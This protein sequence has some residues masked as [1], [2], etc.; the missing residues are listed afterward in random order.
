MALDRGRYNAPVAKVRI[1]MTAPSACRT[2]W[3]SSRQRRNEQCQD[4]MP[5]VGQTTCDDEGTKVGIHRISTPTNWIAQ[6]GLRPSQSHGF[7]RVVLLRTGE[8][9]CV[10]V[11]LLPKRGVINV[12]VALLAR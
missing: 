6:P 8:L 12:C 4:P 10:A 11:N 9:R 5:R 2:H 1:Q 7:W 3:K